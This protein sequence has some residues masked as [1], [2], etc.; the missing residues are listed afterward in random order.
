MPFNTLGLSPE[1]LRAVTEQGYKK[2]TPIQRQAIPVI[3]DGKDIMAGAQTGTGKTAAFT[4]PLLQLLNK[5]SQDRN[6]NIPV[7]ALILTPTRELAAQIHESVMNYGRH[8]N[9]K[10]MVVYGGVSINPQIRKLRRGVD[11]LIATP[12]RLLD[13]AH[14]NHVNLSSVEFLVLDEADRMLDMG[15]IPDVRRIIA[16]TPEHR[17]NLLFFA[18]FSNDVKKLAKSILNAPTLIEVAKRNTAASSIKQ[19][20]HPIDKSR[21]RELISYL[22]GFNNWRQVLIFARTRHGCNRLVKQ[23]KLDGLTALAIHGDKSQGARTRALDEFKNGTIRILVAT[24]VASRGL[25]INNLPHV[26]NYELPDQPED[27][28]HRIGRT[29]RAGSQGQALSLVCNDELNKLKEIEKLLK[30]TIP[31]VVL[32]G[33]EPDPTA[34]PRPPRNN[35][36][37]RK[38]NNRSKNKNRDQK[39]GE[40]KNRNFGSNSRNNS[41]R[42]RGRG[43]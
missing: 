32:E 25:D 37:R 43:R 10:S 39:S 35:Q 6:K 3:L 34:A 18:T 29:G 42:N 4:L 14:Q 23:L 11:I 19:I 16:L 1:I 2:A 5:K 8:L 24:D 12:G 36:S 31:Q 15:F 28:V 41:N 20:I 40:N 30:I 7:R 26:V 9:L 17:Q 27:Y 38:P 33:Y 21:K 22:I 13:L